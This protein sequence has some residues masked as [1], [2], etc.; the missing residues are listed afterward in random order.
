MVGGK[1]KEKERKMK[2]SVALL[3]AGVMALSLT[4][5]GG[6]SQSAGSTEA[7]GTQTEAGRSAA[8]AGAEGKTKITFSNGFT[9]GDGPYMSKI[10]D[11]FNETQDQ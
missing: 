1:S 4:A 9:G 2:K 3:L 8:S 10:D 7:G 6:G 11:G 5:C